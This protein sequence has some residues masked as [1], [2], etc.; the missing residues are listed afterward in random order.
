[1]K[2][3]PS[4]V[5]GYGIDVSH[6]QDPAR[7]PWAE[8]CGGVDFVM[9]RGAY[10][11]SPD[12]SAPAHVSAARNIGA[13]VGIYLFVRPKLPLEAQLDALFMAMEH[14]G[15]ADGDVTPAIDVESNDVTGERAD[16][17]WNAP[18]SLFTSEVA[19]R[20]GAVPI[21]YMS[22]TTWILLDRP[23]WPL[24][25]PLWVPEYTATWSLASPGDEAPLIWQH[26]VAPFV[27][28]G[29]GCYDR[30]HPDL[31]QNRLLGEL[32]LLS[33]GIPEGERERIRGLVAEGLQRAGRGQDEDSG[34][35][36]AE[37][38]EKEDR[39]V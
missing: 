10:G 12:P 36:D 34:S 8:M 15:V 31:D 32:P 2:L 19:G 26:R 22:R 37:M 29:A 4:Q 7:L 23:S 14:A 13:R 21:I 20:L 39:N 24:D 35:G 1:M 6:H 33:R 3:E 25:H 16:P 5:R 11:P 18:L 38:N 30:I 28:D 9:V 27:R 17:S